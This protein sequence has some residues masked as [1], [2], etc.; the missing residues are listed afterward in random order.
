[1]NNKIEDEESKGTWLPFQYKDVR[2]IIVPNSTGKEEIIN[3][4]QNLQNEMFGE[5]IQR[6]MLISKILVLI[7]D[8]KVIRIN[9]KMTDSTGRLN[10]ASNEEIAVG[11]KIA[12]T[13]MGEV[14]YLIWNE[15][16]RLY[17]ANLLNNAIVKSI[18][19][20]ED[21]QTYIVYGE[22]EDKP[23]YITYRGFLTE[24]EA[25][26]EHDKIMENREEYENAKTVVE[27]I[28]EGY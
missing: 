14:Q 16:I 11:E 27:Y 17:C 24:D 13:F 19:K 2:Y 6:A 7:R 21:S 10:I 28:E 12:M 23:M 18:E 3:C 20:L 5:E 25:R 26:Q 1:M 9:K 22:N 4:I 15:T 8:K